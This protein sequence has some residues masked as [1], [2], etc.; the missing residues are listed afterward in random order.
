MT[1]LQELEDMGSKLLEAA[2]KL[3]PGWERHSILKEIGIVRM[4]IAKLKMKR[5]K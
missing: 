2:C 1:S 3:A 5:A 4:K